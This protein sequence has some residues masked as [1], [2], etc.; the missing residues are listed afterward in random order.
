MFQK[1]N[2]LIRFSVGEGI[3][4]YVAETGESLNVADAY[5]D[6]RFNSGIDEEVRENMSKHMFY[7]NIQ[8]GY[9][10]MS[11]FCMPISIRGAVTGVVQMIN[12]IGGEGAFTKVYI[13]KTS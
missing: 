2:Y 13:Y 1:L 12:K 6:E 7:H 3:A 9:Q 8:T 10:T 5:S 4:G 11:L